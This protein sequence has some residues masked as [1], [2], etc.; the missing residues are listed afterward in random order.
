MHEFEFFLIKKNWVFLFIFFFSRIIIIEKNQSFHQLRREKNENRFQ[1]PLG[2]FI[3]W[4]FVGFAR[5]VG[6]FTLPEFSPSW[7]LLPLWSCKQARAFSPFTIALYLSFF[8]IYSLN[9]QKKKKN[10][11]PIRKQMGREEKERWRDQN[12]KRNQTQF[13]SNI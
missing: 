5:P 11:Q 3:L 9:I 1:H 2:H 13:N 6:I 4:V 7:I 12:R 8:G 10:L